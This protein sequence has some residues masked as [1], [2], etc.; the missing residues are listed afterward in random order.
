MKSLEEDGETYL[1]GFPSKDIAC[2]LENKLV[3]RRRGM[4]SDSCA[5]DLL[6]TQHDGD[7]RKEK[8]LRLIRG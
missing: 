5:Y 3:I 7:E 4:L 1:R 6:G 8:A 2:R